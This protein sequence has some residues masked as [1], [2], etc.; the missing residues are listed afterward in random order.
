MMNFKNLLWMGCLSVMST[1]AFASML[2][3]VDGKIVSFSPK[4]VTVETKKNL[5]VVERTSIPPAFN[6]SIKKTEVNIVLQVPPE[7]IKRVTP[8]SKQ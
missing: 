2:T 1:F 8:R 7:G 3:T 5:Y 6:Q 4:E